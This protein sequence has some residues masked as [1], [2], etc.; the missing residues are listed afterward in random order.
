MSCRLKICI[1]PVREGCFVDWLAVKTETEATA[2]KTKKNPE[3]INLK[4]LSFRSFME[5]VGFQGFRFCEMGQCL[6]FLQGEKD[7]E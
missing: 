1:L 3:A 4:T 2:K 7:Q 5:I 6:H